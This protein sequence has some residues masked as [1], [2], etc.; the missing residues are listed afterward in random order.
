MDEDVLRTKME[1]L[2]RCMLRIKS[3]EVS[4]LD[5]LEANLDKQEIIILN[6]PQDNAVDLSHAVGF[7]NI[8]VRQY[9]K[10]DCKIVLSIVQN[11]LDDFKKFAESIDEFVS[12]SKR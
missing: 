10:I 8:A 9:E 7:R 3:Q 6:L 4:S 1:A 12:R 5:E 2:I 11:H